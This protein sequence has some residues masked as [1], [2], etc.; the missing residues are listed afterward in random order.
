MKQQ[1]GQRAL[2]DETEMFLIENKNKCAE[3][4]YPLDTMD[5][6]YIVKMYLD[7]IGIVH[8][9]FKTNFSGPDFVQSFL[10]RHKNVIS[11]SV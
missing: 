6:R 3:L 8:R 11:L 9:R 10:L 5:L 1:G 7:K 4:G 2:S